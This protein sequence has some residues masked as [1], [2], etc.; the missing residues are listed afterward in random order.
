MS[1]LTSGIQDWYHG[2]NSSRN[3]GTVPVSARQPKNIIHKKECDLYCTEVTL[4]IRSIHNGRYPAHPEFHQLLFSFC[5]EAKVDMWTGIRRPAL[6]NTQDGIYGSLQN[7]KYSNA[8]CQ[9]L[10]T[11]PK[12]NKPTTDMHDAVTAIRSCV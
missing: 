8:N 4:S 9:S 6:N 2:T 7:G 3:L 12:N 5:Y 10:L 1:Q 11:S